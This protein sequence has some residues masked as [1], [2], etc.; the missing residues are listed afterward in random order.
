MQRPDSIPAAHAAQTA[1]EQMQ[2]RLIALLLRHDADRFRRYI[3]THPDYAGDTDQPELRRE[4]ELGVLFYLSDEL[5]AHILPRIVRRLSFAAPRATM[6][7]EPPTRGRIDWERT[8]DATW[9]E[10]P[11]APPLTL[12]TRRRRR[13]FA[14]P[15]NLL[16]VATLLEYRADVQHLLW[17]EARAPGSQALRHPLNEIVTRCERELAFPQFAGL[18][19]EAQQMCA[20][21]AGGIAHLEAQVSERL[22]PGGNSAYEELLIWRQQRR[23]L[24]LLQRD[25]PAQPDA[26][27]GADPRRDNYLYQ[28]WIFYE[29][30]DMLT[31][32]G[33]LEA[34]DTTPGAM[35]V[36]F[37]WGTDSARCCY[38]LRH[39]QA[40][41]NPVAGWVADP[42]AYAVPGVRPDFYLR[43]IDPPPEQVQQGAT[44]IW[45]EPGVIWDAKYYREQESPNAPAMP[46]KR[47]LA[48]LTLLGE[49]LGVLLFA[50]LTPGMPES[51]PMNADDHDSNRPPMNA[52]QPQMPADPTRTH[53]TISEN[54]SD[55]RH[56][57]PLHQSYQITPDPQRNQPL[58]PDQ[59]VT[60]QPLCPAWEQHTGAVQ[61][62]LQA[63]LEMAHA[64]LQQP[65]RP[66]CRGVFLDTLSVTDQPGLTDRA[67]RPLD[68]PADDLLLCPKPHI[69][70]WR[71]DLVSRSRHCCQDATRC[72]IIGQ[73]TAQKPVR[74]PRTAEDLL[75]ELQQ[76]VAAPDAD[77][78]EETV[79]AI[80][81]RVEQVTRRFAEIAGAY[82]RIE[83]YYHRLRD[84]GMARTLDRLGTVERESLALAVFLIEQLDSVGAR[85]Y[86]APVIHV[87]SVLELE[88]QR[89]LRACPGL[90][91][92]AFPHGKPTLGT[93]PFMRRHPER[94]GGDWAHLQHYLATRWQAHVDPDDPTVQ[95]TFDEVVTVLDDIKVVRNQAAH[96][97]PVTRESYSRLFR[98]V[99]QAGPLRIGALNVLLLAWPGE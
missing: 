84:M 65:R 61:R 95:I 50:F 28:I 70:P 8:L 4:R 33:R 76:I 80:A 64:R 39:D 75:K 31:A 85:D 73:A 60:M 30:V 66:V 7:E 22:L 47:M 93:L 23:N 42:P 19:P 86:S 35:Q 16:T 91:G 89:R 12:Y 51:P 62:V 27:L 38:E 15:E 83:V 87:A 99:C 88:L 52:A 96:T 29:L 71:V 98:L 56:Q 58:M 40:V 2:A 1:F 63:L 25:Q 55:P 78:D 68:V 48:D 92:T 90:T 13:T 11:D 46:I 14:T 41:P 97:N 18:R 53:E 49:S 77:L 59:T 94:T 57:R 72:H 5:F 37:H 32:Q 44:I 74:P 20:G 24:R 26:A 17:D 3:T 9:D 34:L 43:R 82:R 54:Q 21:A 6:R 69:G 36:R 81:R 45:R 67:G 10:C 79:G